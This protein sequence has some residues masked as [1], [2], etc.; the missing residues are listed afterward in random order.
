VTKLSCTCKKRI[1]GRKKQEKNKTKQK[2]QKLD[3]RE[4]KNKNKINIIIY[5]RIY[6]PG[7]GA[8]NLTR[9]KS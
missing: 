9:S 7:K 8:K 4:V 5:T 3:T 2:K 1:K 6:L